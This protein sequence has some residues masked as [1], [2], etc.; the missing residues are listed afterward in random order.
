M[1]ANER[2]AIS[3]HTHLLVELLADM[4]RRMIHAVK[5]T[6]LTL[7]LPVKGVFGSSRGVRR[8]EGGTSSSQTPSQR[9]VHALI[10]PG[11]RQE[12]WQRRSD[13]RRDQVASSLPFRMSLTL[14]APGGLTAKCQIDFTV[15]CMT[16]SPIMVPAG[17]EVL[18]LMAA[19]VVQSSTNARMPAAPNVL[20]LLPNNV[21]KQYSTAVPLTS[22]QPFVPYITNSNYNKKYHERP[23]SITQRNRN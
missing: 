5:N 4:M 21:R 16:T 7:I 22:I 14:S 12:Q 3:C 23:N 9:H 13:S 11:L 10:C 2:L 15:V 20:L 1:A 18:L 17:P 6:H 19:P 8:G